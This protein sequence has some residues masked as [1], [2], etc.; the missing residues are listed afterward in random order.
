WVKKLD[1]KDAQHEH[2]LLEALWMYQSIDVPEPALLDQLL[3]AKDHRVRAAA[4]RVVPHWKERMKDSL[5]GL[6]PLIG[7]DHPEVR[8]EAARALATFASP[9]AAELAM[10]ALDKPMDKFLDYGLY[11]TMRELEPHWLPALEKGT[12]DFGGDPRK[13]VFSLQAVNSRAGVQPL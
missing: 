13:I 8:L 6:Q 5:T 9:Q 10:R 11:L 3:K 4:V 1:A 7:D 12:L 2:N